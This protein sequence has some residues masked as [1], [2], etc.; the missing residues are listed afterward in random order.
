MP[1]I[2]ESESSMTH[3]EIDTVDWHMH[4]CLIEV[5]TSSKARGYCAYS[6]PFP[7]WLLFCLLELEIPFSHVR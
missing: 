5:R 3:D 2:I 6:R 1:Q 7:H 4:H